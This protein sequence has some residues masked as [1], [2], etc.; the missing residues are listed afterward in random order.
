MSHPIIQDFEM[1]IFDCDGTLVDSE[2]ICNQVLVDLVNKYTSG[3]YTLDHALDVWAGRTLALVLESIAQEQGVTFPDDMAAQYVSQ[4]NKRYPSELKIIEGALDFVAACDTKT[5]ICV[6]SN[7]ERQNVFDS[8]NICG[9]SPNYF[10]EK[11]IFTRIQVPVGKPEPD[12]FLFAADQMNVAPNKCLVIEDSPTGVIAGKAA[13]MHVLGITAAAHD[14]KSQ[15]KKLK[16]AGADYIFTDII[17]MR[18]HLGL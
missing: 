16:N 13:G 1:V 3:Q 17:H 4:C 12:L 6:G 8:L 9:F 18:A 14:V 2:A 10:T 5:K 15:E 11:N 7:G